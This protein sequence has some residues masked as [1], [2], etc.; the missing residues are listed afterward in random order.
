MLEMVSNI[1]A[2]GHLEIGPSA[3]RCGEVLG[4][5]RVAAVQTGVY[6]NN[7]VKAVKE[8]EVLIREAAGDGARL[9]CL[10]EYWLLSKVLKSADPI[11]QRFMKLGEELDAYINLGGYYESRGGRTYL[12][13]Q[14]VSPS[15]SVVSRQD[16]M[17]LYR[18]E[19][20]RAA[21]G[22]RFELFTVDSAR[23]GVLVCH[24]VV[25]PE[26][27]RTM[28]MMGCELLVV[29]SFITARGTEPWLVYLRARALENRVPVVASNV[30][31]PPKC[32]GRSHVIDLVYDKK[33]RIMELIERVAQDRRTSLVVDI[34]FTAKSALRRERLRE[35]R[36]GVYL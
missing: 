34:D 5:I 27:A 30:Y 21:E 12:T 3:A 28:T 16:K 29:P 17:H 32:L 19:K 33:E 15:G 4:H 18:G 36:P 26:S 24:D 25:F 13:S 31:H 10:P 35:L 2:I 14:T 9:I 1:L 23:V 7:P 11:L 20:R 6:M 22:S 8:A